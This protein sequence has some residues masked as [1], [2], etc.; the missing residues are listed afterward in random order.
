[1][2]RVMDMKREPVMGIIPMPTPEPDQSAIDLLTD[3]INEIKSG[4]VRRVAVVVA[5]SNGEVSTGWSGG[6]SGY[7]QLVSGTAHLAYRLQ[8]ET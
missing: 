5:R 7:H 1:M 4:E 8:A 6:D 2:G 3:V